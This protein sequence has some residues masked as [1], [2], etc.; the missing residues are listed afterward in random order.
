[1]EKIGAK[2]TVEFSSLYKISEVLLQEKRQQRNTLI[3][4]YVGSKSKRTN[5]YLNQLSF[6]LFC[7]ALYHG[8]HGGIQAIKNPR[9]GKVKKLIID[10][11]K[12]LKNEN[13]SEL[14][15]DLLDHMEIATA[16]KSAKII[17]W[18]EAK[19]RIDKKFGFK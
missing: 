11:D 10:V 8:T 18:N 19:S 15:E 17:P 9:T 5:E 7:L 12:A 6:S 1:M 4:F 16:K 2:S 3:I 13:F 14:V